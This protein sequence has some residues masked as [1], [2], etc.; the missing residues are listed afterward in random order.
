M[1]ESKLN[2]LARSYLENPT[3]DKFTELYYEA[4]T[5]WVG[6]ITKIAR[7]IGISPNE[8]ESAYEDT[9]MKCLE[10]FTEDFE[11][12]LKR[13]LKNKR[14]DLLRRRLV[15]EKHETHV[16]GVG[17]ESDAATLDYLLLKQDRVENGDH[18]E[19]IIRNSNQAEQLKII[20]H[21]INKVKDPVTTAIVN[22]VLKDRTLGKFRPTAIAKKL[23]VHHS[24]V[25]RKLAQLKKYYDS[26][27]FGDYRD[28]LCG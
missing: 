17:D 28:Y 24:V 14:R 2:M 22:E 23:N 25:T 3:D 9:L 6:K 5:I 11:Y 15:V 19:D 26:D 27:R 7:D 1:E 16:T 21:L 20:K 10:R 12:L 8:L 13:S 4:S 18:G